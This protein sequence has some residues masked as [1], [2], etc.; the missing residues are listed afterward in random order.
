M[1]KVL[2]HGRCNLKN[3]FSA[4]SQ[5]S[6]NIVSR[7]LIPDETGKSGRNAIKSAFPKKIKENESQ[8]SLM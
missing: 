5:V 8:V 2:Q 6:L 4:Q 3:K 1:I 7:D